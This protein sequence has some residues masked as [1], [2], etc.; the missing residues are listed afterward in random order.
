MQFKFCISQKSSFVII[1]YFKVAKLLI[2]FV[3]ACMSCH[4]NIFL[5][6]VEVGRV[7]RKGS[8]RVFKYRPPS[9]TVSY[10]SLV[11]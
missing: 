3:C 10:S 8:Q 4:S 7:H 11:A 6:I 2:F 5:Y 1:A 9:P